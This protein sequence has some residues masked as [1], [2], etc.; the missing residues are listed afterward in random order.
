MVNLEFNYL[1]WKITYEIIL[2]CLRTS[3]LFICEGMLKF[4][5]ILVYDIKVVCRLKYSF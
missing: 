4:E 1:G 5:L 3:M 2:R